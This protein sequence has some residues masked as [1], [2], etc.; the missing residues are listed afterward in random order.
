MDFLDLTEMQLDA[1]REISN[2]GAGNAVTA[3]STLLGRSVDMKV[4]LIK[5]IGIEEIYDNIDLEKMVV[6]V[7]IEAKGELQ[8]NILFLLKE[9]VAFDIINKFVEKTDEVFGEFGESVICEFG[10]IISST[11]MNAV[12]EFTGLSMIAGVPAIA[13]DIAGAMIP[14]MFIASLEDADKILEIKIILKDYD[15]EEIGADFYY[16]PK[17]DSLEKIFKSIGLI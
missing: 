12:S 14:T 11:Y 2:I 17:P 9:D 13:H 1:L 16:L 7:S 10:N 5:V 8:G 3:L 4:P 6:G 15:G